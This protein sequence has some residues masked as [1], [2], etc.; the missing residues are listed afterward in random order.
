M[1]ERLTQLEVPSLPVS[2]EP[3]D[4]ADRLVELYETRKKSGGPGKLVRGSFDEV[5]MG[6]VLEL[7]GTGKKSGRL[8]LRE[9]TQEG[10][11]FVE[12]GSVVY[13]SLGAELGEPALR[14]LTQLTKADFT[15]DAEALLLDLPHLDQDL[16]RVV[17]ELVR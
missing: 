17:R 2:T 12:R 1:A 16:G 10:Y 14:S 7:L 15:Y 9:E 6:E 8:A 3:D 13:A 4:L 11:L 5:S